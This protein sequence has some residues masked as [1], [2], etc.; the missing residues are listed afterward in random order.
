MA[1]S[2]D[3]PIID[4][5]TLGGIDPH[6]YEAIATLEFLG[7]QV[8]FS[9]IV[10]ATGLDE[11]TAFR[12]MRQMVQRGLLRAEEQD[13]EP[14]YLPAHRGWSAAPERAANPSR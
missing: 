2:N 3:Q 14:V 11:D 12:A 4:D 13:G 1:A 5:V 9:D 7:R 6:L 8:R 10:S